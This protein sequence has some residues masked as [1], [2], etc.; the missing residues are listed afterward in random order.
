MYFLSKKLQPYR[1]RP[2]QQTVILAVVFFA[3]RLA[4]IY[5]QLR[6][7][8]KLFFWGVKCGTGLSVAGLVRCRNQGVFVIGKDVTLNSG[9]RRNFVGGDRTVAFWVGKNG[10]L[11]IG[12]RV[13]ISGT[14][15]V[16]LESI[17]IGDYTL[18]GGGCEIYDS[19]FHSLDATE[20]I[21]NKGRIVS[22]PVVIGSN[23]FIG[24]G[25]IILKGSKIGKGSVVGAGSVVTSSIPEY[26]V[27]AGR[28][29]KFIRKLSIP[30]V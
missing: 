7:R 25:T 24:A 30:H 16:C 12:S 21:T 22:K 14:T 15:I 27:W 13:G 1:K 29:A 5:D 3:G 9:H 18:I 11:K 2:F 17:E 6:T 4:D 19:D 20:R 23:A 28:P 10:V 8:I 26:E